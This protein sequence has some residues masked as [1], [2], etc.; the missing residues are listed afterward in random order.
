MDLRP[1]S[2]GPPV[3]FLIHPRSPNRTGVA[4]AALELRP[5]CVD[6]RCRSRDKRTMAARSRSGFADRRTR[7]QRWVDVAGTSGG[8]GMPS[9]ASAEARSYQW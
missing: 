9:D 7:V 8:A 6:G 3:K 2:I 5:G 1:Q 4:F